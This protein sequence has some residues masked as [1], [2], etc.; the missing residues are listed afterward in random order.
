MSKSQESVRARR[1]RGRPLR[2]SA[3]VTDEEEEEEEEEEEGEREEGEKVFSTSPSPIRFKQKII[4][5]ETH[6]L[7]LTPSIDKESGRT[8]LTT[9]SQGNLVVQR[10]VQTDHS[11]IHRKDNAGYTALHVAALQGHSE[12][13]RFLI[14]KGAKVNVAANNGDT[15]LHD[16]AENDHG[17]LVQFLLARGAEKYVKNKEGRR[18][19][20]VCHNKNVKEILKNSEKRQKRKRTI[21]SESE[22]YVPSQESEA[23]STSP[24]KS[25]RQRLAVRS[26]MSPFDPPQKL[27]DVDSSEPLLQI[28]CAEN[29]FHGNG[30][31]FIASQVEES[32]LILLFLAR[33]CKKL[34]RSANRGI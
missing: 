6:Q 21:E 7:L 12:I 17:T 34:S 8:N 23:D 22:G 11:L 19:V 13:V 30:W 18:P 29:E 4:Y 26:I 31:Y 1:K 16:A 32:F 9:R 20:D 14:D 3:I 10:L 15:P 33:S 25:T 24:R 2:N 28:H 27:L 5:L